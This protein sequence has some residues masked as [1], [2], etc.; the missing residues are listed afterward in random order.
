MVTA[1]HDHDTGRSDGNGD[2]PAA[3]LPVGHL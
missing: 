3:T 1:D 2:P